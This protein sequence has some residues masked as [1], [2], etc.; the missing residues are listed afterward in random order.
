LSIAGAAGKARG[1]RTLPWSSVLGL[2]V[3][4]A[5]VHAAP[6]AEE[7]AVLAPLQAFLA[8]IQAYDKAAMLAQTLPD[9][10]I[11]RVSAGKTT[12][13]TVR[14]LVERFP[15]STGRKLE[16]R[17]HDPLI[18]IDEDLAVIWAPYEFMVDGKVDHCGV[19]LV[20]AVRRDGRWLISGLA[21][22]SRKTCGAPAAKPA[23]SGR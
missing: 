12:Q 20:E 22:T 21:D 1:M 2:A 15:A 18:R 23:S 11:T 14:S 9:A 6:T 17:I 8:G 5:P 7:Q 10:M 13:Q 16:E 4:A 19:D 3:L